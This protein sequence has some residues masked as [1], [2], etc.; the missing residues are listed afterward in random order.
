[1]RERASWALALLMAAATWASAG[2]AS[3]QAIRTVVMPFDGSGSDA[4]RAQVHE[5]LTADPRV[6]VVA[7]DSGA[8]DA[9]LLVSGSTSGRAAR[10]SFELVAT[11]AEGNTL[12]TESGRLGRGA[13]ARRAVEEATRALVDGAVGRLPRPAPVVTEPEPTPVDDGAQTGGGGGEAAPAGGSASHDPAIVSIMLGAILR[14]RSSEIRLANGGNLLYD[15]GPYV[16][17]AAR[18]EVRPLAHDPGLGRGLYLRGEYAHAVALGTKLCGGGACQQFD[19][20]FFRAY[21][22]V[23]FLF[24]LGGVAELGAG[25]GFGFEAY[26][27]ADNP[28]MPAVEYPYLRPAVR[29]RIRILEELF[30]IDAE[31][32]L[33]SIFGRGGLSPAFGE[34]G[35][36]LGMDAGLGV[37]GLFDFGLAWR[38][39]FAWAGYWHSFAPGTSTPTLGEGQSGL[40]SGIRAGLTVGYGI[41]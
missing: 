34:A 24:D 29:G 38:A 27:I 15:S 18:L 9:R 39:D 31:V 1:M 16:E 4:V 33:R 13:A 37:G 41:R 8:P 26:Q 3:A 14:T 11:D 2:G 23:G 32:G 30:V 35:D 19:T 20:T 25:V 5:T 7:L 10:R 28:V 17:L 36:S 12:G 22:D 40:D 6:D 21:G